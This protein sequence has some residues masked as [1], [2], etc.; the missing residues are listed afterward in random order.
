MVD[1]TKAAGGETFTQRCRKMLTG[2]PEQTEFTLSRAGLEVLVS[3]SER[4]GERNAEDAKRAADLKRL[5]PDPASLAEQVAKVAEHWPGAALHPR[6]AG[7]A[8]HWLSV[9][10]K[11]P[12]GYA[13]DETS[14]LVLIPD[15]Y[16]LL[17][18][19]RFYLP[20]G[21]E[22]LNS[23]GAPRFT[24]LPQEIDGRVL[25]EFFW[26]ICQWDRYKLDLYSYVKTMERG[27]IACASGCD[28][29]D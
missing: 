2:T 3:D 7:L 19:K 23:G 1:N 6:P 21:H 26:K 24:S 27:L 25:V 4:Y 22:I 16:P 14:M 29:E 5:Y 17:A 10:I 9:P 11:L 20:Y 18:P 28:D 8:G 13:A 15:G 12:S